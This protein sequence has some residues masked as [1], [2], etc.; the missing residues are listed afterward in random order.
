MYA[1]NLEKTWQE[2]QERFTQRTKCK[3]TD[4]SVNY[5]ALFSVAISICYLYYFVHLV[6]PSCTI[7]MFYVPRKRAPPKWPNQQPT[8]KSPVPHCQQLSCTLVLQCVHW[9]QWVENVFVLAHM[10]YTYLWLGGARTHVYAYSV[11]CTSNFISPNVVYSLLFLSMFCILFFILLSTCVL[12]CFV[13][14]CHIR[15]I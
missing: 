11:V 2:K 6:V 7:C 1:E 3:R 9:E 10:V 4:L 8:F 14:S 12:A 15:I 13:L 5:C